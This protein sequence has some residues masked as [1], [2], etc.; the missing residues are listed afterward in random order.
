MNG[1]REDNNNYLIEGITATDY[2]VAELTTTP[3][4]SPDV[5]QEFKVQT[6]LYDATQGRN[7]GGNINA[8]LKS[9][10]NKIHFDA[11]EF[12]RNDA[13]DSNTFF[14]NAAG[15]KRGDLK[16][17]IFG[18]SGGGPLGSEGK[19]GYFFGNYQG[20]RQRSG[21][22]NGT[23]ISTTFPILPAV[24]DQASLLSSVLWQHDDAD[25]SCGARPPE[26]QE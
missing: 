1:Q 26:F 19:F 5:I 4:P 24:R 15:V 10:T 17:N 14:Q 7:G 20:S 8:I 11:Y 23:I 9:G 2:N 16:Q 3:L 22:D 18:G 13:L 21:I 6:S 12:F 25:R